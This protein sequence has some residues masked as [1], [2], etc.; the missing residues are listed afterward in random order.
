M[1]AG[2]SL[3]LIITVSAFA[4]GVPRGGHE[5]IYDFSVKG[6]GSG[7]SAVLQGY[8]LQLLLSEDRSIET[9]GLQLRVVPGTGSAASSHKDDFP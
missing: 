4:F 2:L 7:Q 8:C 5:A 9:I 6:Q 3:G 1:E